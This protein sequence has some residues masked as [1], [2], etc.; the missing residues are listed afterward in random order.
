MI[1]NRIWDSRDSTKDSSRVRLLLSNLVEY[2]EVFKT[3]LSPILRTLLSLLLM[4][5]SVISRVLLWAIL[6]RTSR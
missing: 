3:I 1:E 5:A 6:D 2:C 4:K